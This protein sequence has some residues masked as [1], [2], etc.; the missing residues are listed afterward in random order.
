M[1]IYSYKTSSFTVPSSQ[2]L[3]SPK[4]FFVHRRFSAVYDHIIH[5]TLSPVHLTDG[6]RMQGRKNIF[7]IIKRGTWITYVNVKSFSEERDVNTSAT[8]SVFLILFFTPHL[9]ILTFHRDF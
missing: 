4:A 7:V 6:D 9:S 2:C 3:L 5:N 1:K 8:N